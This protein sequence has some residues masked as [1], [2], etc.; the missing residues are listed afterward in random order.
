[1]QQAETR[2]ETATSLLSSA[3]A[4]AAHSAADEIDIWRSRWQ[5]RVAVAETAVA[6][7][8]EPAELQRPADD[9]RQ[10][11]SSSDDAAATALPLRA[12]EPGEV[13]D[14]GQALRGP[15]TCCDVRGEMATLVIDY[16][17]ADATG[18]A[19]RLLVAGVLFAASGLVFVL[20]RCTPVMDWLVRWPY[21]TLVAFGL[22]WW[23]WL[24]PSIVGL[25]IVAV[26]VVGA[27]RPRWRSR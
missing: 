26:C 10:P 18:F 27:V 2:R 11:H 19:L 22:A 5:H 15:P 14:V 9:E 23:L 8:D 24:S 25:A 1:M 16:P 4:L 20:H 6:E 17:N 3:P 12:V 21:V 7:H 13:W